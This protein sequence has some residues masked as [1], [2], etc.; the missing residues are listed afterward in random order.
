[1][2][3]RRCQE[4]VDDIVNM[5][6]TVQS[7]FDD[8]ATVAADLK[9]LVNNVMKAHGFHTYDEL[10]AAVLKSLTPDQRAKIEK[11]I[12]DA[13]KVNNALDITFQ[14]CLLVTAVTGTV[15]LS[16]FSCCPQHGALPFTL[17]SS[18][19]ITCRC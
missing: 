17:V 7:K 10:E 6:S 12:N 19:L 3:A 18:I 15:G 5:Q 4:M 1:M 13:K 8:D 11:T 2:L 16:T 14:V 9:N